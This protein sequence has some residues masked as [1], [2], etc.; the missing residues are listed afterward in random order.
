MN[1]FIFAIL[2]LTTIWC[3]RHDKF[4]K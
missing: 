4:V 3:H 1:F 2:L